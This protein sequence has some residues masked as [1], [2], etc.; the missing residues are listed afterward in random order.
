MT[1]TQKHVTA[2]CQCA[3][4]KQALTD[5]HVGVCVVT[6]TVVIKERVSYSWTK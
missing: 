5:V 3:A 1:F 6:V 2:T 4:R